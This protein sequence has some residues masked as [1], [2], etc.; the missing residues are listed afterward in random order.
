MSRENDCVVFLDG[1]LC[2]IEGGCAPV[3][4]QEAN[5]NE[6]VGERGEQV[7]LS[8]AWRKGRQVKEAS[9]GGTDALLVGHQH[10]DAAGSW[11]ALQTR[12]VDL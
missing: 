9:V 12:A 7:G 10:L 8:C 3:V 11:R 6:W 2:V 1:D 4:T 5:R